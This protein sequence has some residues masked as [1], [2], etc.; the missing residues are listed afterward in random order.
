ML[1]RQLKH[2]HKFLSFLNRV[3]DGD[4]LRFSGFV[5]YRIQSISV[6]GTYVSFEII[7]L[8]CIIYIYSGRENFVHNF[9]R[10]IMN[11][12]VNFGLQRVHTSLMD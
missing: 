5:R 8:S 12:F 3:N 1:H 9:G 4:G 10:K 7:K 6:R 2:S 11:I